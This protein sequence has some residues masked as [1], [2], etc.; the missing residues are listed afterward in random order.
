MSWPTPEPE[1]HRRHLPRFPAPGR[2]VVLHLR[3]YL[4]TT[5][6]NGGAGARLDPMAGHK[7]I[8]ELA[9]R[10]LPYAHGHHIHIRRR[11]HYLARVIERPTQTARAAD[12][13]DHAA[14]RTGLKARVAAGYGAAVVVVAG[15]VVSVAVVVVPVSVVVFTAVSFALTICCVSRS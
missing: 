15:V 12:R 7:P 14:C 3:S 6:S 8:A 9:D 5:P 2:P 13:I 1:Q 10:H 4:T 11:Q